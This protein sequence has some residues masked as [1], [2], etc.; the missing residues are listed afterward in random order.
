MGFVNPE[1]RLK[2]F[3]R[4]TDLVRPGSDTSSRW[5]FSSL[6]FQYDITGD[7]YK[8]CLRYNWKETLCYRFEG[9]RDIY[10]INNSMWLDWKV[11][12]MIF[13]LKS[14]NIKR[15]RSYYFHWKCLIRKSTKGTSQIAYKL[16][17]KK[18]LFINFFPSS[19]F[20]CMW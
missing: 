15:T 12:F 13:L 10:M 18:P 8:G 17:R 1:F 9:R 11:H 6:K 7:E 3:F 19:R 20:L 5:V 16:W 14:I 4:S 2:G